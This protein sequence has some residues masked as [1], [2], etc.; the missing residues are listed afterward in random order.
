MFEKIPMKKLSQPILSMY[1]CFLSLHHD[2]EISFELNDYFSFEIKLKNK[3]LTEKNGHANFFR[4]R[5][6]LVPYKVNLNQIQK[7]DLL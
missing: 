3:R 5:K 7:F 2:Y 4:L 6:I 1:S